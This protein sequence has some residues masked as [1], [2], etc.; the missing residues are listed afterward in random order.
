MAAV[1]VK[2][3]HVSQHSSPL[4][5]DILPL[6]AQYSFPGRTQ[7]HLTTSSLDAPLTDGIAQHSAESRHTD[8]LHT[9]TSRTHD[10]QK[11]PRAIGFSAAYVHTVRAPGPEDK[12]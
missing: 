8:P 12:A 6:Y 10:C 1:D 3:P 7:T 5:V 11:T 4:T 2:T 9:I